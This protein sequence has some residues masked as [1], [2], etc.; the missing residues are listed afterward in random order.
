MY[1]VKVGQIY[2]HYKGKEYEIIAV[3]RLTESA[4]L[5]E[6]VVYK[7]LYDCP[8]FGTNSIWIRP[9]RMFLEHV[10]VD[11]KSVPRFTPLS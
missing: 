10:S 8:P 7:A 3:G 11:G 4:T 5:E 6:C 9:L 2:R 1:E